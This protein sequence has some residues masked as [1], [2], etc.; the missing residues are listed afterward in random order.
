MYSDDVPPRLVSVDDAAR[1]LGV[2]GTLVRA[3]ERKGLLRGVRLGRVLRVP[4]DEI[5][6]LVR[7]ED[8]RRVQ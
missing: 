7:G 6:R 2:S 5:E 8:F 3:L 1:M 4:V